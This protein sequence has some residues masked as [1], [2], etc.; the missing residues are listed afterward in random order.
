MR[1]GNYRK[2]T[3][4]YRNNM[5][6][7]VRKKAA[8]SDPIV[9]AVRGG[10]SAGLDATRVQF[11]S[12][13]YTNKELDATRVQFKPNTYTNKDTGSTESSCHACLYTHN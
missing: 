10:Q 13:T 2:V 5:L 8:A 12:N 9:A 4:V 7:D 1:H 6:D 11:Q 3:D